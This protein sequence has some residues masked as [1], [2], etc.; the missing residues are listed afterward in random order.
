L[1]SLIGQCGRWGFK[2][3]S[4]AIQAAMRGFITDFEFKKAELIKSLSQ[5]LGGVRGG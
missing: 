3:Q 4:K 1:K 5:K 2:D